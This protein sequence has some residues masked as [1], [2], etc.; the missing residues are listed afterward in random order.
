M[1]FVLF[2]WKSIDSILDLL[3]AGYPC[4]VHV[5]GIITRSTEL[6]MFYIYMNSFLTFALSNYNIA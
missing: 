6:K 1:E 2:V 3:D 4:V 5:F